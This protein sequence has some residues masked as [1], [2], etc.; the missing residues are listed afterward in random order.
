[1]LGLRKEIATLDFSIVRQIKGTA[2]TS[3]LVWRIV[4]G[5]RG[6]MRAEW[7]VLLKNISGTSKPHQILQVLM[8]F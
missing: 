2:K 4:M 3:L 6:K 5:Y 1:M 7:V 8:I